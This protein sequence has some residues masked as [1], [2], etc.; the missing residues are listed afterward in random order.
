MEKLR[1]CSLGIL[2]GY[3]VYLLVAWIYVAL[4]RIVTGGSPDTYLPFVWP[5]TSPFLIFRYSWEV[6]PLDVNLLSLLGGL[7]LI[8]GALWGYFDYRRSKIDQYSSINS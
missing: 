7:L 5:F 1:R 3:G 4:L 8:G 6:S 2:A